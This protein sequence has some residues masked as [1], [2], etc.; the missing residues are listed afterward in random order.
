MTE[1]YKEMANSLTMWLACSPG[2]LIVLYQ[3]WL[4]FKRSCDDAERL[5]ISK[6][7]V[8]AAIR[9]ASATSVGPCF[10]MLTAMLALM[11]YVGGPLAWLR[12]DFIGSVSYELQGAGYVAEGMGIELGSAAMDGTFLSTACLVM[13]SGCVAWVIFAAV[14]ADK[15][16]VVQNKLAGGNEKLVPIIGTGALIGVYMSMVMDRLVPF[17]TQGFAVISSGI[18]MFFIQSY[19]KKANKQWLKEWGITICMIV[20]AAVATIIDIMNGVI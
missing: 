8:Q 16:E 1:A 4:F 7:D 11:L 9:S 3:A 14:F 2:V 5:G 10:V 6:K 19:N 17:K 15:M 20:G 18:V 12:V 13:G